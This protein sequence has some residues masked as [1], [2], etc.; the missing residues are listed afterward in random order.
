MYLG[1][2]VEEGPTDQVFTNPQ[3]PYTQAL[4]SAVPVPDPRTRGCRTAGCCTATCPP[5][6]HSI[7]VPFRTR[8]WRATEVCATDKPCFARTVGHSVRLPSSRP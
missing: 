7:G 8:C 3:H 2:I 1:S 6:R 5:H 4:L